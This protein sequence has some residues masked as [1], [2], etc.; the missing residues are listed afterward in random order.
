[1]NVAKV[2]VTQ[3]RELGT[4]FEIK[5]FP[6][7]KLISKG[8]VYTYK[9]RRTVE[10]LAEFARGGYQVMSAEE[11]QPPLGIFGEIGY[12]YTHAL[13]QATTDLKK[14]R[15]FTVDVFLAFL[16]AIFL[17]L[18]ALLLCVPVPEPPP[19]R[20]RPQKAAA[21]TAAPQNADGEVESEGEEPPADESHAKRD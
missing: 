9:G 16:P 7:I 13:K 10:D 12:I 11:V 19:R 3:N 6:T 17:L 1:M 5:G 14:G 8:K 2:D 15:V 20:E 18:I 4:R 21:A